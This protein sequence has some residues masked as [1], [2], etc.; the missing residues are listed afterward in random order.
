[1]PFFCA[2]VVTAVDAGMVRQ[3][4][5]AL[6]FELGVRIECIPFQGGLCVFKPGRWRSLL[7]DSYED[8]YG[9]GVR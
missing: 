3:R 5:T 6:L 8:F 4:R 9:Q 1:M 7:F 2:R